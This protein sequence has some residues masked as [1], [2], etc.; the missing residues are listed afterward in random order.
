MV[1]EAVTGVVLEVDTEVMV[2]VMEVMVGTMMVMEA[3]SVIV[4]DTAICK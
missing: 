4:D 3:V 2:G 1:V